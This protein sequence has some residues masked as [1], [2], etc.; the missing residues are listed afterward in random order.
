MVKAV[1]YQPI[2]AMRRVVP[3][4]IGAGFLWLLWTKAQML[5]WQS[6][7]ASFDAI[8]RWRWLTAACATAVSFWAIAQY[9]VIAHR[10][11]QT[12]IPARAAR[13]AGGCAIAVSQT[14]GF[15]PIIGG[16]IRW[17]MMPEI[18]HKTIAKITGFVTLGFFATWAL[19]T[20]SIGLP[21]LT[22]VPVLAFFLCPALA[23]LAVAFLMRY[24]NHRLFG[25]RFTLPSL[26]AML[27][28]SGLAA[29]DLLFAGF[30]LY[31]LLPSELA[32]S[33]LMLVA[34]FSVAL[35]AGMIGGTPGG[36]GPFELALV[37]L[38]P[39][40]DVAAVTAAL[41]AFRLVYYVGPCLI[42]F[43]YAGLAPPIV[44]HP[45][46]RLPACHSGPR[47]EHVITKQAVCQ[48]LTAGRSHATV[49]ETPQ[50]LSLFLGPIC[51]CLSQLLPELT[52]E[53]AQQNR[54]ATLYKITG[55]DAVLAKHA[56][57]KVAALAQ[58]AV[59]DPQTYSTDG[60][61]RRQL[62]RFLRKAD[63]AGL[64]FARIETPDWARMADIHH[65]WEANHGAERGLTMGRFCPLF[66]QDKAV[67]GAFD[68]GT[69]VAFASTVAAPD[70]QSL[71]IMR[72]IT[73]L[74]T[75]TM[76]GLIHFMIGE[77]QK[78][79]IREFN[80]AAVPHPHLAKR[81]KVS[82]GLSRFKASFSPSWRSLYIA[83]PNRISL[84][85]GAI[86]LWVHIKNPP[87]IPYS[88]QDAWY[89]DAML[90]G[91][92]P[93]DYLAKSEEQDLKIRA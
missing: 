21:I 31:I 59:I 77:A 44:P 48:S 64:K 87:S 12:G 85:L 57:W 34:A 1:F 90:T 51:G 92:T 8:P 35:G 2:E 91:E 72:H 66:L 19:L 30:A 60:P 69:L 16:A 37:T 50:S 11:F 75:G 28:M 56:G 39:T 82:S 83:A 86:D 68:N 9:D 45:T 65:E 17:R 54:F 79:G 78:D 80:L 81:L 93:A 13:A 20:I 52:K 10:H 4:L 67:F 88:Q 23:L 55:R 46:E 36:V 15:G 58:E 84:L 61:N 41:I 33:F 74:P 6:V 70:V 62:R 73:D 32:P 22:G 89:L 27:H 43:T 40:S 26:R 76:H 47:A 25:M 63:K 3:M 38:V 53:A 5:D 7:Q 49:L 42:G 71:D 14:T 24:P 18:G 29:C